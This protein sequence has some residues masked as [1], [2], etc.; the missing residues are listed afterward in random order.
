MKKSFLTA[1][2]LVLFSAPLYAD[3]Q[4]AAI[5]D[6]KPSEPGTCIIFADQHLIPGAGALLSEHVSEVW[7]KSGNV[8][9]VCQGTL[10]PAITVE[11]GY[12]TSGFLGALGSPQYAETYDTSFKAN[13]AGNWTAKFKFRDVVYD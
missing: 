6:Q 13:P 3:S 9:F 5:V 10:D 7:T 2:S 1:A 4:N 12:S 8:S 11:P